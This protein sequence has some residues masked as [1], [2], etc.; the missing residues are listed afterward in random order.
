[1]TT[2]SAEAS[3]LIMKSVTLSIAAMLPDD[4]G[5]DAM[6]NWLKA[7]YGSDDV[8]QLK[9][10]L[11]QVKMIGINLEDFWSRYNIALAY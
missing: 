2:K 3:Y 11:R 4:D 10:D 7:E 6:W 9:R 1:M 5:P 8:Y